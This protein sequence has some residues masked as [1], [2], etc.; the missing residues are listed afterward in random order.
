M[1]PPTDDV[2]TAARAV[3]AAVAAHPGVVRLDGGPWGTV[4]SHL[5]GRAR[6]D[7]VR[8]GVGAE[9][10]EI[11][12]VVRLG[13]PLPQLADE[14]AAAVRAVLGP[15]PVDVTFSDVV[16]AVAAAPTP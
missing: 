8:L 1:P 2:A 13:I 9:P 6:V 11:A 7:G 10:V 14:L 3:A 15:V 5:P 16:S 4:A 12:V